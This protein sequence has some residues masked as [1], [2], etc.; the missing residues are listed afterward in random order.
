MQDAYERQQV[1]LAIEAAEQWGSA[2]PRRWFS[3]Y[4]GL[5]PC[6]GADAVE[7]NKEYKQHCK[8]IADSVK[9]IRE[10]GAW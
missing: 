6:R 8:R 2:R 4:G 1:R 3:R 5:V 10:S 9:P 7:I